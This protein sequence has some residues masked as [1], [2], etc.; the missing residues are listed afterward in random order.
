MLRCTVEAADL[1]CT[2]VATFFLILLDRM[3]EIRSKPDA[4]PWPGITLLCAAVCR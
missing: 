3:A 1:C 4:T 2:I